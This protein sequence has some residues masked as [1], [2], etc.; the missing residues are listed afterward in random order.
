MTHSDAGDASP[1][2]SVVI[3]SFNSAQWLPSTLASVFESL[4]SAG[5]Q[6]EVVVVDDGSTDDTLAVLSRLAGESPFPLRVVAQSNEGKFSARLAGVRAARADAIVL[7]D[8]RLILGRDALSYLLDRSDTDAGMQA[9]NGH[10]PTDPTAPLVGQFWLVPTF[11]FW[12]SY[13]AN[14][15]PVLITPEN[16]DRV[17]KGTTLVAMARDLFIEACEANIPGANAHLVSDDTKLLRW[18]SA[19]QPIRLEPGFAALYRPRTTLRQFFSH[20]F[21]RGTLF[22]DSYAGTSLVRNVLLVALAVGPWIALGLLASLAAAG[23]WL[24]AL[25][26]LCAGIAAALVP[27]GLARARHCPTRGIAAYGLF[28]VPFGFTFAAGLLRGIVVH[29]SAFRRSN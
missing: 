28:I 5:R 8:S 17:P 25:C 3:P 26:V 14:P 20:A 19:R 4:V 7:M 6:A 16:F 1:V 22:V 11:V 27:A 15:R 2:L 29:R 23:L 21:L 24:A 9:W 12:G 13:L 10:V 18:I